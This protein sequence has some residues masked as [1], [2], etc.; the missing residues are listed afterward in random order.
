[1]N[2]YRLCSIFHSLIS[3]IKG[4]LEE[5]DNGE[6]LHGTDEGNGV[7]VFSIVLTGGVSATCDCCCCCCFRARRILDRLP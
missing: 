1:M 6:E 3:F 5:V 4:S 7:L 2:S